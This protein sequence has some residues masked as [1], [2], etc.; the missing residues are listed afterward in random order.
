MGEF[1]TSMTRTV[2]IFG[3]LAADVAAS[4][5]QASSTVRALVAAD[6]DEALAA[7]GEIGDFANPAQVAFTWWAGI[8]G[9]LD[10]VAD[11]L[12][13]TPPRAYGTRIDRVQPI[14]S[15]IT[16]AGIVG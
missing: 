12:A 2:P 9:D 8:L 7:L 10:P 11:M 14:R 6:E 16:V 13:A 5:V 15:A 4:P 3:N 1:L